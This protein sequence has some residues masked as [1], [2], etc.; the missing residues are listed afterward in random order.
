M[1]AIRGLGWCSCVQI[2]REKKGSGVRPDKEGGDPD[3][4]PFSTNSLCNLGPVMPI[5]SLSLLVE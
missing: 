1:W 2:E 3:L 5:S 4:A